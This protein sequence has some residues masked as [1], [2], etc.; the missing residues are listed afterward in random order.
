MRTILTFLLL[1]L[2]VKAMPQIVQ[3]EYSI[4]DAAVP[5]GQGTSLTVPANSGEVTITGT[6]PV[7]NLAPGF[8]QAYFRVKHATEGWSSLLSKI[9]L[10]PQPLDTIVGFRYSIDPQSDGST[11]T[12]K[13]FPSPSPDVDYTMEIDLGEISKGIH[14]IEAMAV[15]RNGLLTPVSKGIFFSLYSEPLNISSLEYYFEA[16][17]SSMSQVYATS[18]F[19]P[20]PHVTLDSVTFAIPVTSLENM[21]HY[22]IYIR[23]V[24]EAGNKGFFQGDTIVYHGTTG[25]KD[26]IYLAT[27]IMVYPNPVSGLLN[28]RFINLYIPGDYFIRFYDMAGRMVMEKEFFLSREDDYIILET[29]GLMTGVYRIIVYTDAGDRVA[30][31]EFVKR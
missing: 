17:D 9:F 24:D 28:M 14:Y 10:I 22:V 23:A 31:S 2:A 13:T 29:S 25:L 21:K 15:S 30:Q 6:L 5:Y 16:E 27:D 3:A 8:H 1:G 11:W 4:D 7:D 19:D 26:R 12:Y 18:D 20:S